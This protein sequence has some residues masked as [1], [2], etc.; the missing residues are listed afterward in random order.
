MWFGVCA[1][2]SPQH[3]PLAKVLRP[4]VIAVA[5]DIY[6]LAGAFPATAYSVEAA[7]GYLSQSSRIIHF[8]LGDAHAVDR[9]QVMGAEGAKQKFENVKWNAINDIVDSK[10]DVAR[11]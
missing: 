5:P 1:A 11:K 4:D 10:N 2:S 7:T 6:S 8:E 9:V 3:S